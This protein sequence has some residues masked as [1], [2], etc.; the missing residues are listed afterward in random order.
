MHDPLES[1]V[2][3]GAGVLACNGLGREA[4]WDA[5]R[6][7]KSGIG[8]L[9]RFDSEE[10][11]CHIGGQ[12]WD[13]DPNDFMKK[14]DVRRSHRHVQQA[15]SCSQL[16]VEDAE[17]DKAGYAPE[18]IAVCIGTSV[19]CVDE[20]YEHYLEV[21]QKKGWEKLNRLLSSASSGHAPTASVS[22]RHGFRGPAT[23]IASG[24]AT[25]LDVVNWGREQIRRGLADVAV[26]GT[27]EAPLSK[28]LFAATCAMGILSLRN[29]APKEA[30]RPFD[31]TSDGLVLSEAACVV[32]LERAGH[33]RARG[34]RIMGEVAG[35][36]SAA[37]GENPYM[38][39][40][41]GKTLARAIDVALTSAGMAATEVECAHCHGVA[42]PMYDR[43]ETNGFKRALGD[44]AYRIPIS[45][46][47]S[48]IGQAYSTGGLLSVV[49]A[50]QSLRNGVIPPT[51]NLRSPDEQC[52][53]DFVPLKARLNDVANVLVTTL[54]FGGTHGALILRTA[55]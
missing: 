31:S 48:M 20:N 50:L 14:F 17:L 53:L 34:A 12:L 54:S 4:F 11:P 27:T 15:V 55:A 41:E 5:I 52:D 47:K 33:A 1:I 22:A 9:D 51:I 18:R 24:C 26:V 16:A 36:G 40:Q 25:G 29:D 35:Y 6:D 46:T 2:I 39:D 42:I 28:P 37:E 21:F 43:C 19:G 45:A 49:A 44:H 23:T 38:L 10:F 30:M 7:G 3:T 8:I 13:F 32:V